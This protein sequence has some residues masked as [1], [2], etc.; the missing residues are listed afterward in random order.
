MQN[1]N[2]EET[3][4]DKP[5]TIK[6]PGIEDIGKYY[7]L[8]PDNFYFSVDLQRSVKF[9]GPVIVKLT[10]T[11]CIGVLI[12]LLVDT[13]ITGDCESNTEIEFF[14]EDIVGEYTFRN[15]KSAFPF[16]LTTVFSVKR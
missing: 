8:N 14:N 11:S 6:K 13:F 4:E 2:K 7:Q 12:G 15:G 5:N 1:S 9:K 16:L 3:V 10:H